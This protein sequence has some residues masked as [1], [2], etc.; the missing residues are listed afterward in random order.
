MVSETI[1]LRDKVTQTLNSIINNLDKSIVKIDEINNKAVDGQE[2]VQMEENINEVTQALD[3]LMDKSDRKINVPDIDVGSKI[4][5][6]NALN[7]E[8][9]TVVKT[10]EKLVTAQEDI[11]AQGVKL[12]TVN[13]KQDIEGLK[14]Q[15]ETMANKINEINSNAL[16][17]KFNSDTI[18]TLQERINECIRQQNALN[19]AIRTGS[20]DDINNSYERLN[21]TIRNTETFISRNTN[22]QRNFKN[23]VDNTIS[24]SNRLN[25][26]LR[27]IISSLM[28]AK[29]IKDTINLSDSLSQVR[30]RLDNCND[31]LQDTNDL[32][33]MLKAVSND[34][35]SDMIATGSTIASLYTTAKDSFSSLKEV[36]AFT[37][38]I[39]K[40][41]VNG[42]SSATDQ[43][44]ALLQL[45]QA[46]ASGQLQGDEFRSIAENAPMILEYVANYLG[47][48]RSEVKKMS[49]DGEIT[50]SV[51]KAAVFQNADDIEKRF[52]KMPYT[53][54][55]CLTIFK[56]D[57]IEQ[58]EPLLNKI[59]ELANNDEFKEGFHA[60]LSLFVILADVGVSGLELIA[61]GAKTVKD[62]FDLVEPILLSIVAGFVAYKAVT[63]GVA[64]AKGIETQATFAQI[65]AEKILN[66]EKLTG[67]ILS[68]LAVLAIAA[69]VAAIYIT[70]N[71]INKA[72]G[73][74]IDALGVIVGSLNV[75][76]AEFQ[77]CGNFIL[78]LFEGLVEAGKAG[79]T[80]IKAGFQNFISDIK[81]HFNNMITDAMQL[82]LDF[83]NLLNKL[84][85]VNI[86]TTGMQSTIEHYK[87]KANELKLG[88]ISYESIGD[89]FIRGFGNRDMI[90]VKDAYDSG[91]NSV[92]KL[93]E[94]LKGA[95]DP[96]KYDSIIKDLDKIVEEGK[97]TSSNTGETA[98]NTKDITK[99]DVK[100]LNELFKQKIDNRVTKTYITNNVTAKSGKGDYR[101][102]LSMAKMLAEQSSQKLNGTLKKAK[103]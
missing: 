66:G 95:V 11:N 1:E 47:K 63:L 85:K 13:S 71:A 20:A 96:G 25:Y 94:K 31:G 35:R 45:S 16:N 78:N 41:F 22:Q 74:S 58:M 100:Y 6:T 48:T 67:I 52:E 7:K 87:S 57:A 97:K 53:W 4:D 93:K 21:R 60:I 38:L 2:F 84:P 46:M 17:V 9:E 82:T 92:V 43:K 42:A 72:T 14:K 37:S 61:K 44:N 102:Q 32:M 68:N 18:R 75:V 55:Q 34:T 36:Y 30:A 64:V 69:V 50:A 28:A 77:N 76:K 26:S 79:F 89:A 8:L 90:T 88:K 65:A 29:G 3:E 91:Y 24:S 80:N 59:S 40:T 51:I 15:I 23:E 101:E 103:G 19:N 83:I 56:N 10:A 27:N 70:V 81:I 5:K 62:N 12:D 99:T 39:N 49:S 98:K 86:D 54:G 73:S 33:Q